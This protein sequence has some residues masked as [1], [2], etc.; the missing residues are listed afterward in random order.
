M[1]LHFWV[2]D[3]GSKNRGNTYILHFYVSVYNLKRYKEY[4][5]WI[6]IA[7]YNVLSLNADIYCPHVTRDHT[8]LFA[9]H[10]QTIPAF[11]PQLQCIIALWLVLTI[12]VSH[13]CEI[14]RADGY[15]LW[16]QLPWHVHRVS[17]S[18]LRVKVTKHSPHFF[19]LT[20]T[21][22][23]EFS[24]RIFEWKQIIYFSC[25]YDYNCYV[26]R[27]PAFYFTRYDI[28]YHRAVTAKFNDLFAVSFELWVM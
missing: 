3:P 20:G 24:C 8:F 25:F 16:F 18:Q 15:N 12:V 4:S 26:L 10:T 7:L 6:Y 21:Y 19:R 14:C 5:R 17:K 1:S 2:H 27:L 13:G 11:T 28:I 22:I 23:V 9:T